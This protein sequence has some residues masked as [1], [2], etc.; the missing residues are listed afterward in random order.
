MFLSVLLSCMYECSLVFSE[1][2][3][4]RRV[5]GNLNFYEFRAVTIFAS[6]GRFLFSMSLVISS[7]FWDLYS[8]TGIFV[9]FDFF[10]FASFGRS[11]FFANFRQFLFYEFRTISTF[12]EF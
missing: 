12:G 11:R 1:F 10:L 8:I 6:F 9:D 3:C 2:P 4:F 5:S 7:L